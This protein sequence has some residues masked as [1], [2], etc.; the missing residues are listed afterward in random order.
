MQMRYLEAL[1]TLVTLLALMGSLACA[2]MGWHTW[3]LPLN[4]LAYAAGGWSG[5]KSALPKLM[6]RELDVNVLM[7]VAAVGAAI[8]GEWHEGAILLFLFSLSNSL[9]DYAMARSRRAIDSLLKMRPSEA[10]LITAEGTRLT[11]IEALR[12]GD[13]IRVMPGEML[14]ADGVIRSGESDLNE[15]SITGESRPVDKGAGAAVYAGSMN[16]AGSLEVEVTKAA[17]DSTLARIV[18]LVESAQAQKSRTQRLLDDV[19]S[20]YAWAVIVGSTLLILTP[21]LLL[22]QDFASS[23]YRGMVL[24]VVASPCALVIST[25]ASILSAI[26]CGARHGVLFKGGVHLENLAEVR[27]VAFD[28]TGT[29]THGKLRLT[30]VVPGQ[31]LPPGFG[32]DE[33][34]AVAAS[35]E[36]HSEHPIARAIVDGAAARGLT[37]PPVSHFGNLTGRGA[38]ATVDGYLVWIGGARLFEEHGEEV[39]PYLLAEKT[40]LE[41]EGNTVLIIHREVSRS[42]GVGEHESDGGWLGLVAV[43]DTVREGVQELMAG[44]RRHGIVKTVILTGDN[45]L[46]AEKVARECGVDEVHAELLPEEKVAML[47]RLGEEVGPVLMLG[48]G[49]N[50]APALAHAAVG[51]A[52]GAVGSDVALE[53]ADA[54]LMGDDLRKIPFALKLSRRAN[55]IVRYNLAFS[56]A[57]IAVLVASTFL[58]QLKL[59]FGVVGHEG[60]TLL[61]AANGL[62]LLRTRED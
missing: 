52:M 32:E 30:A 42:E 5:V 33:V 28:K 47:H 17:Q 53:S 9:Q 27:V 23:F 54:V 36:S 37:L 14:A 21:W 3:E 61:V 11:P 34:L 31:E 57:V 35:L 13:L 49:V 50:D 10:M 39:P 58:F 38:H 2:Y 18:E 46:V 40:R 55:L 25:P 48:D 43:A 19:E 4:L 56:L 45:R 51:M 62:R 1:L 44:L 15:A 60:S 41:A 24:L 59:P 20:Y 29:L 7:I 12:P 6:K 16:G 22:G 26:A 8:V